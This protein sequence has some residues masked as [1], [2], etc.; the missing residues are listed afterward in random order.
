MKRTF[1]VIGVVGVLI[2][3]GCAS[4]VSKSQYPVTINSTPSGALVTIKN[5]RGMEIHKGPSPTTVTLNASAGFFQPA[6]YTFTFEKEGY[7]PSSA[8]LSADLDPWYI[9][10]IFFGG[11]IGWFIVD[12]ATGSMW[13]LDDTV[14][15][16]LSGGYP[17]SGAPTTGVPAIGKTDKDSVVDQPKAAKES[18]N[19]EMIVRKEVTEEVP[20]KVIE[21]TQ[22]KK[23]EK[24][25]EE[26]KLV[27]VKREEAQDEVTKEVP[28]KAIEEAQSKKVEKPE[29]ELKPV[30]VKKEEAQVRF[31]NALETE[32]VVR[33]IFD[34]N[35][36]TI[37][38]RYE[39]DKQIPV[40]VFEYDPRKNITASLEKSGFKVVSQDSTHYD[41]GLLITHRERARQTGRYPG[42]TSR[43]IMIDHIGFVLED[44]DG[45]IL[46]KEGR[47]P[48]GTYESMT[49]VKQ[50]F[51][52][53][54][55]ELVQKKAIEEAQSKKVEKPEEELKP[56]PVKKEEAQVRFEKALGTETEREKKEQIERGKEPHEEPKQADVPFEPEM[57]FIKGGT[58][59]MGSGLS[60]YK[61]A[62]KYGGESDWFEDEHPQHEVEVGDF[63]IGKYEVTFAQY[64]TFCEAMGKEKPDDEG[65]GRGNRP[66][67]RVNWYDA[68]MFCDWTSNMTGKKYRL[69]TEAEWEYA[70]VAG[71]T[72][73]YSFGES[74]DNLGGY[75]WYRGNSGDTT[76]EV[77]KLGPNPWSLYDRH[78]NVWEWCADW[79]GE[80]YYSNSLRKNPKGPSSGESRVMRGGS[81]D[82][83][84][85]SELRSAVRL[86]VFP[87]ITINSL[88]FRVARDP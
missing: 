50:S 37:R 86:R 61:T 76:H 10:N 58:F 69:P 12:P 32:T 82:D 56:V 17:P 5:E 87:G 71:T 85:P 59:R 4:I 20:K 8:S 53:D 35:P 41:L 73:P 47:G 38:Y 2:C 40:S 30:P 23:V 31:E 49:T 6:R 74:S 54:L 29:E 28:K 26:L 79:Y 18:L 14:L 67:I 42:D 13:R 84:R 36:A 46:L 44:K 19:G 77:G 66:A 3:S 22:S 25:E 52:K 60:A 81:W 45:A 15:A 7:Y 33:V 80:H 70:C 11:L 21:E 64:D 1:A 83:Y 57:V 24:P 27:R 72:T 9:G 34:M 75:A 16:N 68:M 62:S 48:F 78:G 55:V 51:V 43:K 39:G 63:Y 88:G 65:W